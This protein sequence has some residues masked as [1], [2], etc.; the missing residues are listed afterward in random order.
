MV[1]CRIVKVLEVYG[2]NITHNS[3]MEE[4]VQEIFIQILDICFKGVSS[5]KGLVSWALV[6]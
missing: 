1:Y 3:S 5:T 4:F 6:H 2:E